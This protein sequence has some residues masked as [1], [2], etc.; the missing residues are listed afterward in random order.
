MAAGAVRQGRLL[1]VH[2]DVFRMSALPLSAAGRQW[3]A[4]LAVGAGAVLSHITAAIVWGLLDEDRRGLIHVSVANHRRSR[5]GIVVHEA[6]LHPGDCRQR[7]RLLV[8]SLGRTAL[9]CAATEPFATT[10]ALMLQLFTLHKGQVKAVRATVG[11]SNGHRGV[12]IVTALLD[13]MTSDPGS[14]DFRSR[15]ERRFWSIIRPHRDRL[16]SY[17]R[18]LLI[19]GSDGT[20]YLCD[21]VFAAQRVIVELDGR[22]FHDN[23]PR[24]DADRRRDQR[25]VAAGWKVLRI[26][27]RH[28]QDDADGVIDDLLACLGLAGR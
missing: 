11:R 28:L 16:P 25:L 18:N 1:R 21:I 20:G 14:G 9:D 15:L 2:Q 27:W 3:A 22:G 24:F 5:H 10:E 17:E 8:T 23:D 26:T 6:R 4:L 13:A 7:R 12:G 19:A